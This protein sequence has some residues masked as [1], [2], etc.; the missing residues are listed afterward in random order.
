MNDFVDI[1]KALGDK[2]RLRLLNLFLQSEEELCVCETVEA[3][4][5]P[6]YQI[7]R[8]LAH[9][10]RA[11]LLR[12]QRDGTWAYYELNCEDSPFLK[13][14][15]ALMKDHFSKNFSEDIA[16]LQQRLSLR[17]NGKCVV[18]FASEKQ[19]EAPTLKRK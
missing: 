14:F 7:S 17:A 18:G 16:N 15:A 4:Q 11:G 5:L 12:S 13:D 3:L 2:T 9:L 1:F 10:R 19:L 6:Q 8:H